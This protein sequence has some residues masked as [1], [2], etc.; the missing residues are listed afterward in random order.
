MP[1]EGHLPGGVGGIALA[2]G[3]A[4]HFPG[5]QPV[6]FDENAFVARRS[7]HLGMTLAERVA[8][9]A[10]RLPE[11]TVQYVGLFL[12]MPDRAGLGGR[13]VAVTGY[14]RRPVSR[15]R[16]W[17][18]GAS[19]RRTNARALRWAAMAQPV[20]LVGWGIW[21]AASSGT[22]RFFD[23]L[24]T[25]GPTRA[26]VAWSVPTGSLFAIGSGHHGIGLAL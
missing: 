22:L 13:E 2:A 8:T 9:L 25:S 14:T 15:W 1:T 23:W 3:I 26:P 24:R 18:E 6:A 20:T 19:A 11:G 4:G 7:D 16:A 12:E 17:T 21:T 5:G 10:Q